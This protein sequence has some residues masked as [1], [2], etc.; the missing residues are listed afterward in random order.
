MKYYVVVKTVCRELPP[1][2]TK[3]G[4]AE[5]ITDRFYYKG[6]A[7]LAEWI[8]AGA[9]KMSLEKAKALVL[10][11]DNPDPSVTFDWINA[12]VALGATNEN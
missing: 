1:D 2:Q 5:V 10:R 12:K 4:K 8:K 11:L 7:W 6:G 3:T 9:S